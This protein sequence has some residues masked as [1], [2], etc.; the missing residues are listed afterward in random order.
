MKT[1]EE[2]FLIKAQKQQRKAEKRKH[3]EAADL[4]DALMC[5]IKKCPS[6]EKEINKLHSLARKQK[7]CVLNINNG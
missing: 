5:D 7:E 1:K 4:L 3:K 6:N 2:K